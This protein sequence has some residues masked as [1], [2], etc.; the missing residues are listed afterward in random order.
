MSIY[1]PRQLEDKP[2][3]FKKY[4]FVQFQQ[5]AKDKFNLQL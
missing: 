4:I 5:S 3:G 1:L 2:R